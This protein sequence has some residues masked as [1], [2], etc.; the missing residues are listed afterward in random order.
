M[1]YHSY[2]IPVSHLT[3]LCVLPICL[4]YLSRPTYHLYGFTCIISPPVLESILVLS[5]VGLRGGLNS[6]SACLMVLKATFLSD[7]GEIWLY[8]TKWKEEKK[9]VR[10]QQKTS[11]G[12]LGLHRELHKN[13]DYASHTAPCLPPSAQFCSS[14]RSKAE[15]GIEALLEFSFLSEI[16]IDCRLQKRLLWGTPMSAILFLEIHGPRGFHS[17]LRKTRP[18]AQGKGTGCGWGP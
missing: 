5:T 12:F 6:V 11:A 1:I 18:R 7:K 16:W 10:Q 14:G 2:P 13:K 17:I 3:Y 15:G 9:E 4:S 8:K